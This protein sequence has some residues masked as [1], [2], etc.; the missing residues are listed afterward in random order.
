MQNE[1][2]GFY[3]LLPGKIALNK[4][5]WVENA[6]MLRDTG[7]FSYARLQE[8]LSSLQRYVVHRQLFDNLAHK[9]AVR[10]SLNVRPVL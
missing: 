4:S 5:L 10:I 6:S 7:A 1:H 8:A 2:P 9:G 3:G